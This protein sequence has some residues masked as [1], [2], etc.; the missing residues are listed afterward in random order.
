MTN[1]RGVRGGLRSL[2]SM[3]N[4]SWSTDDHRSPLNPISEELEGALLDESHSGVHCLTKAYMQDVR[5]SLMKAILPAR[6][7]LIV[8]VKLAVRVTL[9]AIVIFVVGVILIVIFFVRVMINEVPYL[10]DGVM[11]FHCCIGPRKLTDNIFTPG[12]PI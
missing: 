11:F 9:V 6:V 8:R 2:D 10:C 4:N 3:S 12:N 7:I 5:E 1:S